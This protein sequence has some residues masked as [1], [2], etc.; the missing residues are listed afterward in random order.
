M[1]LEELFRRDL[2]PYRSIPF[3]SWNDALDPERLRGQIRQMKASGIGGFFMHAR[4]G[5]MTEYLG[6]DWFRA[7]EACIDEARRQGMDAWCYDEN[8]W[9]SGFA[10]MKLLEDPA[11]LAHFLVL[12]DRPGHDPDALACYRVEG[13]S[14]LRVRTDDGKPCQCLYDRV[15]SSV[16]DILDP[17][18]VAK[19][20]AE[21]HEKY[22]A[23]FAADFGTPMRGFFTD[24]PQYFRYETAYSP[25]ML[26]LYRQEYGCDLL[27]ELGALLIDCAESPR[28]RLRYWRLMNRQLAESF[29]RQIG[30]WCERHNCFLT[31]HVVEE[32]DLFGQMFGCAGVMPFYEYEQIPGV[33][34]LGRRISTEITPR[35]VGSVAQQ[36]GK[37]QVLTESFACA[38]WNITP[39][40]LRRILEWQYVNGVNLL[41]QHLYPYSIRG[42]RKRDYPAFYSWHNPWTREDFKAFNDYFTNLGVLLAESREIA[43]T[44][45]IHPMHSAYLT[46]RRSDPHSTDA[47][48]ARFASLAETLG[49]SGIGHHYA[50][51]TLLAK[52]GRVEDGCLVIGRCRYHKVVVPQMDNLDAT[53]WDLLEQFLRQGGK[54]WLQ[55]DPPFLCDGE[56]TDRRLAS[57]ISFGELAWPGCT[58]DVSD[59]QIR[60]TLRTGDFGKFLYAVNLSETQVQRVAYRITASGASR[61]DPADRSVSPVFHTRCGDAILL[62]LELEPGESAVIL[63]DGGAPAE[64]CARPVLRSVPLSG[65]EIV[66]STPNALTLDRAALSED[67]GQTYSE[68]M[69]VMA[70]TDRLLRRRLNGPIRLRY[71][72]E[73]GSDGLAAALECEAMNASGATLNGEPLVFTKT[74]TLDASFLRAD[75]SGRIRKGTNELVFSIDYYQPEQV[76]HIFNGV[77]YDRTDI[78]ESLVNCLSY[79]TDIEAVYLL[80]DFRIVSDP[81]TA[82]EKETLTANGPFRLAPPSKHLDSGELTENGFPFFGGTATLSIPFRAEG[83]ETRLRLDGWFATARVRLNGGEERFLLF[84]REIDVTGQLRPGENLL[85]V[86]LTGSLRNLMGPFHGPDPEPDFVA[87]DTFTN[88]GTWKDGRSPNCLDRY[89]FVPFGLR[90]LRLG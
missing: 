33:D 80:G 8:G 60:S 77:Y 36:L 43:D 31:G 2:T 26:D 35:Q 15:N 3:W 79:V 67:G 50:D 52:Y 70:L 39:R 59:T 86:T 71:R 45:M 76:Y 30:E 29:G 65:C 12:E 27:D 90:E 7:V 88:F 58:Q 24:E 81:L 68:P 16:V 1:T 85:T 51:E 72:F 13:G 89:A 47:L 17:Q 56:K 22:Y 18:I 48:Q 34:W 74:G 46:F 42:Q 82:S 38:G 61:F 32:Q 21:T 87:P 40:A 63:L 62:P 75:L 5:L 20:I 44:V 41:C 84:D 9:P 83:N 4:G 69:D 49:A 6:E 11:N 19:F 14:L 64:K 78:T 25:V 54:L 10:G 53:T 37:K 23:R 66:S 55:G 57:N 73:A 28:L